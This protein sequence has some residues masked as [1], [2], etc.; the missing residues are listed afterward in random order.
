MHDQRRA[1]HAV[2]HVAAGAAAFQ[3]LAGRDGHGVRSGSIRAV[4]PSAAAQAKSRRRCADHSV[5]VAAG[6]IGG[7]GL[8]REV[9]RRVTERRSAGYAFG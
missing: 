8:D 7:A 6:R 2:A 3:V 4:D 5:P 1:G 9:I